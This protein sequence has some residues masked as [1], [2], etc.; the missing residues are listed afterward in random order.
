ME[1]EN[2][3]QKYMQV[4]LLL[5]QQRRWSSWRAYKS[6]SLSL[7]Y[8]GVLCSAGKIGT[9]IYSELNDYTPHHPTLF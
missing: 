6:L 4:W 8:V 9:D 3:T 5:W 2:S 7:N 1:F